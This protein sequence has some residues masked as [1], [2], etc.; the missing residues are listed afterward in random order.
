MNK[1]I[2]V[3]IKEINRIGFEV[4]STKNNH[5]KVSCPGGMVLMSSHPDKQAMSK[6]KKDLLKKGVVI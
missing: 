2:K 3:L 4:T 6:I 5:F 1:N